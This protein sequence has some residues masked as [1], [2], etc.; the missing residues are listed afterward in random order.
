M[1]VAHPRRAANE[2]GWTATTSLRD[3]IDRTV[4]WFARSDRPPVYAA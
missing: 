1:W 2:L 3:G 4:D